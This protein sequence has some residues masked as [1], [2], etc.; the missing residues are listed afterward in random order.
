MLAC[1]AADALVYQAGSE[2]ILL[3][4]IPKRAALDR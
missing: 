1:A 4:S 3:V 2:S